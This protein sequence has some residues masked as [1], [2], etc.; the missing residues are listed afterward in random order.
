MDRGLHDAGMVDAD[1]LGVV[2]IKLEGNKDMSNGVF[3]GKS[4]CYEEKKYIGTLVR[5]FS[6][7]GKPVFSPFFE[8]FTVKIKPK[9]I[10]AGE[11]I[12]VSL[13]LDGGY[14]LSDCSVTYTITNDKDD[15]SFY[16]MTVDGDGALDTSPLTLS[17]SVYSLTVEIRSPYHND[18]H[19]MGSLLHQKL[20][21]RIRFEVHS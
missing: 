7:E 15:G 10:R 17:P 6:Q 19:L 13:R 12:W 1:G 9:R 5:D 2:Q 20:E 4:K 3:G 11:K 18:T 14:E 8:G 16:E 21:E